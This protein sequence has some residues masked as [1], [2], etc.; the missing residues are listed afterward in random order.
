MSL[1]VL[2]I[3]F[4]MD[5]LA[6]GPETEAQYRHRR[7]VEALDQD[8]LM[9]VMGDGMSGR[10]RTLAD[11]R[12][13]V[14]G[15][16]G[17]SI[18]LR[19]WNALPIGAEAA[20]RFRPDFIEYQDPQ[21]AGL[22]A[23]RLA[24]SMGVPLLG[25][26]FNDAIEN[27][28]WLR[29]RWYR[30]GLRRTALFVIRRSL[31]VRCDAAAVVRRLVPLGCASLRHV[32]FLIPGLDA[33]RTAAPTWTERLRRWD[34][35][36]TLLAVARLESQ[37]NL[38]LL[39]RAYARAGVRGRLVIVGTGAEESALRKLAAGLGL[40]DRVHF[41]GQVEYDGLPDLMSRSEVFALSSDY[42]TSARVLVLAQASGLPVATTD[43]AGS[44]EIVL[45]GITG[46]VT[47]V[48]NE[49]ALAGSLHRL[50]HERSAYERM[51]STISC[52]AEMERFS[53]G[54]V[55][56][57]LKDFYDE[58]VQRAASQ[59]ALWSPGGSR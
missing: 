37:K 55:L 44:D 33:F 54:A 16:G 29:E 35:S 41:A 28:W 51:L 15:I 2:S 24:R 53:E 39:L 27:E 11:G 13:R 14:F 17:R 45:D 42:E 56:A 25:G 23:W 22:V 4:D 6:E 8:R 19:A 46:Y 26:L 1:R 36:P 7:Y 52:R 59:N 9:I 40:A 50:L 47:P 34:E 20:R 10:S 31:L 49:E 57:A 32:P 12:V 58:A 18:A 43:S 5:L 3:G 48:G 21:V 38:A 30:P